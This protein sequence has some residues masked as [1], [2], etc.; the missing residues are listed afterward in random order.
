MSVSS[1]ADLGGHR[2]RWWR[3]RHQNGPAMVTR[4]RL[5]SWIGSWSLFPAIAG[6]IFFA[7][8]LRRSDATRSPPSSLAASLAC[9]AS[10]CSLTRLRISFSGT[11]RAPACRNRC[12]RFGEDIIVAAVLLLFLWKLMW[13]VVCERIYTVL[14]T[15][16][17]FRQH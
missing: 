12:N 8:A 10:H 2:Q 13:A 14:I 16:L 4:S 3:D 5:G 7:R 9:V 17:D 11:A 15:F 6:W 1:Y